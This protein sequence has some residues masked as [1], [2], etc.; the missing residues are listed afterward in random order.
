MTHNVVYER[1]KK[2]F[3]IL[4]EGITAWFPNGKNSIRIRMFD[5]F[6]FVFTYNGGRDWKYETIDSF[7]KNMRKR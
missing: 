3:P 1:F 5:K 6:D 7:I 2:L 4:D